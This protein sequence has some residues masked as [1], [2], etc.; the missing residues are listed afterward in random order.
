MQL[1]LKFLRTSVRKKKKSNFNKICTHMCAYVCV[2]VAIH[3]KNILVFVRIFHYIICINDW[4]R[5]PGFLPS[6]KYRGSLILK[7]E[8]MFRNI[9]SQGRN[10]H[11]IIRVFRHEQ[12]GRESGI[13]THLPGIK[14]RNARGP[15][16]RSRS[17]SP[18]MTPPLCAGDSNFW[19]T[20]YPKGINSWRRRLDGP[21]SLSSARL[22]RGTWNRARVLLR[23]EGTGSRERAKDR[24]WFI[25]TL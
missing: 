2:C 11:G 5:K 17:G 21:S 13:L 9:C 7:F 23:E 19:N 4:H 18:L 24:S 3:M 15:C 22:S 8:Y 25:A 16:P 10:I 12:E 6:R 14:G 20:I 1:L